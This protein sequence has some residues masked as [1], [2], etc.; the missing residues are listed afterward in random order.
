MDV[1]MVQGKGPTFPEPLKEPEDLQRLQAKVDVEKELGYVF[2]AIT[3]T[4]HKIEGKVPLI[5]FTGAPW[6]LMSY[7]IEGGGSNTHSKAKRWLYRH[8][9]ASHMLLK[10]LTDVIV[11]Y[12][13]GQVAAGAQALQVFESHAGILGPVE[14]KEFSLP[15][16]RDIARRVKDKLKEAGQD[17]PMIV[18]AKDAHYGL[19]DL[20]QSYY[21]VVGLD[22]TIDPR[23]ARERTGGKVSLQGN[24]DPCALYSPKERISDI[25]KKMVEGF[26]TRGYIANLGHGLY[27]DMDPENVGAF[28]EA[29][30]Q[31]S[32][33]MNKRS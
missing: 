26:G 14:F 28:V 15:Y 9:E 24:M 6:T 17:V 23:S 31:H 22:W 11:E 4:R 1:Q 13:L 7:M 27:P 32:K 25:V 20:S 5:G 33:Q 18:F 10:M 12:L 2:R 19:E 16:L 8:P 3:L 30:H 29:V 21:E